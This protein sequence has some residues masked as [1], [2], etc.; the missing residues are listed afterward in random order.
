VVIPQLT[1]VSMMSKPSTLELSLI[2]K[3]FQSPKFKKPVL[4]GLFF[5]LPWQG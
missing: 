3:K 1:Q 4:Y 2:S 5:I